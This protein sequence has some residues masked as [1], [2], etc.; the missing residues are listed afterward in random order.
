METY[1]KLVLSSRLP[2]VTSCY[3]RIPPPF[4]D[5]SQPNAP[6]TLYG[7]TRSRR[8]PLDRKSTRDGRLRHN[9]DRHRERGSL[10]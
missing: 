4:R 6:P 5:A 3:L 8:Q 1:R 10:A 9:T 2:R 7:Y